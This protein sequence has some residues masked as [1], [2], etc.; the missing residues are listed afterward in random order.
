MKAFAVC[1]TLSD[2]EGFPRWFPGLREWRLLDPKRRDPEAG[3]VPVYGR[4]HGFGPIRDR[5]YVV[6]YT[7]Q[8]GAHGTCSL[9]ARALAGAPPAATAEAIRI[10]SMR[11]VW[12]VR[13]H[14][15]YGTSARVGYTVHIAPGWI[16]EWA[17]P[18]RFQVAPERLIELLAEEVR[19]RSGK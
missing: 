15:S 9:E 5:D 4:Q 7:L 2:L 3:P 19:R 11:T 10:D 12:S 6:H 16:P 17:A 18:E 1:S 14:D 8:S 13:A